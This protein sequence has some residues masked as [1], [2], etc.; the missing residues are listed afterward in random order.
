MISSGTDVSDS[1][2]LF[3]L[4]EAGSRLNPSP[5]LAIEAPYRQIFSA[6]G[7]NS[8]DSVVAHFAGEHRPPKTT[9]VVKP[10]LISAPGLSPIP[11]FYK[12]YEYVPAAWEFIFRPSKATREFQNYAA[13]LRVGIPCAE[14]IACGELRDATGRLRRAFII[15]RAIPDAVNLID[16]VKRHC[17]NRVT[18]HSRELRDALCG[19]LAEL[20]RS[21]HSASFFH[22]DLVW[23]NILVTRQPLARPH[24]WWIDC[25]R[26]SFL[27]WTP[28][29]R[30][31]RLKDLASL[32]KTAAKLCTRAE[33]VAFV[34]QYLGLKRLDPSAKRLIRDVLKYREQRWPEDWNER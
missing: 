29:R 6:L 18:E 22:R 2:A 28:W 11:V 8:F 21:A 17:P 26:G 31:H 23:R 32:D 27:R 1:A 25:P 34:R 20:T 19:R 30:R 10:A 33:R 12:Q 16:F 14:R 13:F 3:C 9:V 5:M 15:T 7:L 4:R 24:L